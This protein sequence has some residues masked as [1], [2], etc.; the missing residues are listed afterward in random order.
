MVLTYCSLSNDAQLGPLRQVSKH[1]ASGEA[2]L[3]GKV[4]VST[5]S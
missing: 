1:P 3:I 4:S 5:R 2:V